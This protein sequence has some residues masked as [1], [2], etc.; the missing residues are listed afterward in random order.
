[1]PAYN[2]NDVKFTVAFVVL[3]G[4]IDL[5][6][7][8][9]RIF[10]QRAA[11]VVAKNIPAGYVTRLFDIINRRYLPHVFKQ[12]VR[13]VNILLR[14]WCKFCVFSSRHNVQLKWND[15]YRTVV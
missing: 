13:L 7:V 1:M 4:G 15:Y 5:S 6:N 11:I 9:T 2:I 12:T 14:H 3:G 10:Q 8:L